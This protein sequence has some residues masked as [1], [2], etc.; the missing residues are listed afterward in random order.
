MCRGEGGGVQHQN[1][2]QP[3]TVHGSQWS[4]LTHIPTICHDDLRRMAT[5]A[6]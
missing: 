2:L 1:Q 6:A 4:I 5:T 3:V